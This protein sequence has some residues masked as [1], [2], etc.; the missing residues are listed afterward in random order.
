MRS[1]ASL[2][3]CC[4]DTTMPRSPSAVEDGAAI[5]DAMAAMTSGT[6]RLARCSASF[7]FDE[8]PAQSERRPGESRDPPFS[9]SCLGQ[10]GPG[11]RR[12]DGLGG[13]A[14]SLFRSGALSPTREGSLL[15]PAPARGPWP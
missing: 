1:P 15:T 4:A 7:V 2:A 10:V 3:S 14:T 11:F 6:T 13:A 5:A 9:R 8:R 12:D